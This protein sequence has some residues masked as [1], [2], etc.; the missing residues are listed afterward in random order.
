MIKQ[1][2]VIIISTTVEDSHSIQIQPKSSFKEKVSDC[3]FYRKA[4][5]K[6]TERSVLKSLSS[7]K[8]TFDLIAVEPT[9]QQL[10]NECCQNKSI[11][12]IS[13]NFSEFDYQLTNSLLQK[14]VSNGIFFEIPLNSLFSI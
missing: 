7:L 14:A 3:Q 13:L 2:Q 4:N 9:S 11:D 1:N 6:I 10:L 12:I 8:S 5:V